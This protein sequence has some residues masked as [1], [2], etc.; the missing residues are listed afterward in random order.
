MYIYT[1]YTSKYVKHDHD[2]LIN[3][4]PRILDSVSI[5]EIINEAMQFFLLLPSRSKSPALRGRKC[6]H[7]HDW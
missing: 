4:Y 3:L 5:R 2:S 7:L 6:T 1:V